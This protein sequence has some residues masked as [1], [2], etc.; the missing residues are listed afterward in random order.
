MNLDQALTQYDRAEAN[1]HALEE[2]VKRLEE[3]IPEGIVFSAGSPE[4]REHDELRRRFAELVDALPALN[5]FRIQAEPLALDDVAQWRMDAFEASIP[6]SLVALDQQIA[7]PRAEVA[8]YRHRFERLRRELS[9]RR[10][11]ELIDEIGAMLARI[12]AR[13]PQ[14]QGSVSGDD[15]WPVLREAAKQL[16]RLVGDSATAADWPTLF[17]HLSFGEAVDLHDIVEH[18]WPSVRGAVEAGM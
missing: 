8:D 4:G 16:R 15:E 5:G 7:A 13:N 12:K 2:V 14:E 18:D 6:E 17:R 9:R 10:I 3:M 11:T 1:L